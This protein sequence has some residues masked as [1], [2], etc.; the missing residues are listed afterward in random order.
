MFFGY[1]LSAAVM[2]AEENGPP[3]PELARRMTLT[4]C[5]L[6]PVRALA[7]VLLAMPAAGI[8]LGDIIDDSGY[9][10]RDAEAWAIPLGAPPAPSSSR[11]C[12]RTTA[13]PAAPTTAP[14]SPTE[15]LLP[16]DTPSPAAVRPA[17]ARR[18][19]RADRRARPADHRTRPAQAQP[20][21]RRRR[22]RLPP[23][24]LSRSDGEDPLPAP[25]RLNDPGPGPARD[26]HPAAAPA[27]LLHPADPHRPARHR[28]EDPAKHDYPSAAWRRSY[29]RRTSAERAFATIKDTATA[30]IARGWCRLTGLTPLTLWLACVLIIRNQ[31]ILTA[32]HARQQDDACSASRW[33]GMSASRWGLSSLLRR[34]YC[35]FVMEIGSRRVHILEITANPDG[36]WTVQQIRNLLMDLGDRAADFRFLVRD[37]AGQFTRSFDAVL[38]DA[39]IEAVKIP[40]RS[41]RAN[42]Y[43]ER[44]ALTART[45]VTDRMLIFG[46]RHLQTILA[47]YEAHYNRRRPHRSCHLRPPR[48]DH[49]VAD[50]SWKRIQR[51]PVLGGFIN[52]YERAA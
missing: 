19:P 44:F 50:L 5:H 52:E 8:A 47:E 22:R 7:A 11:T 15:P 3:V 39:G 38:A 51:R 1:F 43:A 4:S 18:H 20:A 49:P 34:L 31:R 12:T 27:S 29:T 26:P 16:A 48:P 33:V 24:H 13:A 41:P 6:D 30:T 36:P 32:Y 10:H 46:Q 35:L 23:R 17:P 14:S 42:A 2:A 9:A 40:P 28:R 25:P 21:H 45:Q 37:R